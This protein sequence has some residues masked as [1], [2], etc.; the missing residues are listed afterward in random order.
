MRTFLC[1]GLAL[2]IV[3]EVWGQQNRL[4]RLNDPAYE[5]IVRLQRRGHLLELNPTAAPYRQGAVA[6][7]LAGI[8]TTRLRIS[9]RHWMRMIGYAVRQ[10]D[11]EDHEAAVGYAVDGQVSLIN[12]DRMDLLRPLGDTLNVTYE[13]T[14]ASGWAEYG[15]LVMDFGVRHSR[16]YEDDPDGLDVA[17]RLYGRSENAYVGYH[18][19]WASLYAGRWNLHWGVPGDAATLISSNPRSQD[20]L[21]MRLGGGRLSVTAVL[22]ELDSATDG[23]YFTGRAADDS[24]RVGSSRRYL[25]AHRWDF[26]VGRRFLVSLMESAIYS[27]P[28]AGL[29]LK[30]LNPVHVFGFVVDNRPKNDENNGLVAAL[31]WAQAAGLTL[32]GQ[33]MVDD[34]NLQRIGNESLTF[35]FTGSAVYVLAGADVGA[36]LE[37]VSARAYNAPQPA[38]RYIYLQRGLAT[39]FSDYVSSS[40]WAEVHLD[41]LVPGLRLQPS[42]SLLCQGE[43]DMRQPF[44]SNDEILDNILD[45]EVSR[46]IR[47][48]LGVTYQPV[49][50]AWLRAE[51][52]LNRT[53]GNTRFAGS[54][55]AGL[56][57]MLQTALRL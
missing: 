49:P 37:M 25:A 54:L 44:P 3:P 36:S 17:L 7:A 53:D 42:V 57:L 40:L 51:G 15:S 14:V 35:A 33:F 8:D 56:R 31:V 10:V 21:F 4:L 12:S 11:T 2:L 39:Q 45:G 27:G 50:W 52:G 46:T 29:S 47:P 26:R 34:I 38:G 6:Q 9:E 13:S 1:L 32:H 23:R 24:V 48:A 55:T 5:Y 41:H 20:Q 30:Y 18:S 43:R 19:R 16:Y 28:G 22:S